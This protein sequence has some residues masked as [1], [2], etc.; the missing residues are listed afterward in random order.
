MKLHN[1]IG[2]LEKIKDSIVCESLNPEISEEIN[3]RNIGHN[4]LCNR[5][6][7]YDK[8]GLRN[9][10]TLMFS[11]IYTNCSPF[12]IK[13]KWIQAISTALSKGKILKV[14]E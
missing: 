11:E 10:A 13:E 5:K 2:G 9:L 4:Q 1:V 7:E 6:V 14:V 8:E 12:E 3:K